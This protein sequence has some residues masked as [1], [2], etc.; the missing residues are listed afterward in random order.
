MQ[1]NSARDQ[2]VLEIMLSIIC[3]SLTWM[4]YIIQ[5]YKMVI[6]NIFF[7]PIVLAGFYLG[8]YRAGIMALFCV[9]CASVATILRL[10]EVTVGASP[11][12]IAM[13]IA[14][15]GA[16]LGLAALLVGTLSDDR[17]GKLKELHEAYVGVVQVLS[18]YLQSANPGLRAQSTRVAELSQDLAA[19]M[20]L[21]AR[22]IDDIRVAALLYDMGNIEIT[23]RVIRKAVDNF[24]DDM[25]PTT[26]H[27]FHGMD[28]MLSLGSVLRGAIPLLLNQEQ[29]APERKLVGESGAPTEIPIGARIIMA[30]RDYQN[31]SSQQPDGSRLAPSEV[32]QEMRQSHSG[33]Y[34]SQVL[35]ALER[36]VLRK[37]ERMPEDALFEE[38]ELLQDTGLTV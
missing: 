14:V 15:W 10:N 21:P 5:G 9:L 20:N 26:Q 23:T 12:V 7:L 36:V 24:E 8:R 17:A 11:L 30:A 25:P 29:S 22:Q 32:V 31:L 18:Q 35:N 2:R 28:L 37:P 38:L 19:E 4:L 34:D 16:V 13:A 27:T 1:P 6:L 3:F 33:N